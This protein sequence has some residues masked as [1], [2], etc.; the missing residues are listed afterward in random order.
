MAPESDTAAGSREFT[1][2]P[3]LPA[4][5]RVKIWQHTFAPRVLELHSERGHYVLPEHALWCSNC[6]NPVTLS[7]CHES[8]EEALAFYTVALPLGDKNGD[9]IDRFLY[10]NPAVDTAALLGDMGY[11]RLRH[12]FDMVKALDPAGRGLQRIGLSISSW[13][14]GYAAS[15]LQAWSKAVFKDLEQFLLLMYTESRPPANFRGGECVMEDCAGMEGFLGLTTGQGSRLK[16]GDSW[17]VVG[18]TEMR[19]MY[20]NFVS[21]HWTQ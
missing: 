3:S 5:L 21:D 20:L 4:E 7:V 16:T 14:H 10:M 6:G 12:L 18:K 19:V 9:P 17:M 15:M 8:R 13:A 1:L 2:F 11:S